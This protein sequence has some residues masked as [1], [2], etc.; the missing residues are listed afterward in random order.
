MHTSRVD[1]WTGRLDRYDDGGHAE[2][3]IKEP[4]TNDRLELIS[5]IPFGH[6][7]CKPIKT[8]GKVRGKCLGNG[9]ELRGID[10]AV[11]GSIK[12]HP[13]L[14]SSLRVSTHNRD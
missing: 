5:F 4:V 3:G 13:P 1:R 14:A 8:A 10:S 9:M 6:L 12:R 7:Y 2:A 11:F